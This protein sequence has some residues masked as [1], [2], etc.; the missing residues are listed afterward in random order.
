MFLIG[1]SRVWISV[2]TPN[3]LTE[4]LRGFP[5]SLKANAGIVPQTGHDRF[6][7]D[8]SQFIIHLSCYQ[9]TLYSLRYWQRHKITDQTTRRHIPENVRASN[10]K[11]PI[12]FLKCTLSICQSCL[13]DPLE[14]NGRLTWRYSHDEVY[15]TVCLLLGRRLWNVCT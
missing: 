6:L 8:P 1:R 12:W 10:L 11:C 3:I 13:P 5:Q 14:D 2:E 7:P 4:V 15:R 9:L